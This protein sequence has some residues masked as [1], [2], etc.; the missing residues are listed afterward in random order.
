MNVN[1]NTGINHNF[2]KIEVSN[3][4]LNPV[5]IEQNITDLGTVRSLD[6]NA[7]FTLVKKNVKRVTGLERS[8]LGL[9]L[10][11]L[12]SSLGAFW[13][14][15]GNYLV[16]NELLVRGLQAHGVSNLELSSY[17]FSILLHEYLH[18]LGFIDEQEDR[19]VVEYVSN[20][21]FGENH[22]VTKL[23]RSNP[24]AIYPFLLSV[25]GGNGS[26]MRFVRNFDRDSTSYIM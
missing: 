15:S 26:T 21:S 5:D 3:K 4:K 8:G 11:D 24:W 7:I 6:Y 25:P 2:R 10:S 16:I 13:E 12:P 17:V 23:A 20:Q 22:L 9:A 18:S 1:F 19:M 14:V